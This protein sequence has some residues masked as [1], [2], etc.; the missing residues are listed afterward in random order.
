MYKKNLERWLLN[1]F[2]V[3]PLFFS[4]L[5]ASKFQIRK[6]EGE[7]KISAYLWGYLWWDHSLFTKWR[8]HN[9]IIYTLFKEPLPPPL[10]QEVI[11]HVRRKIIPEIMCWIN[12]IECCKILT[13]RHSAGSRMTIK[14]AKL[15]SVS[16]KCFYCQ[17][18]TLLSVTISTALFIHSKWKTSATALSFLNRR[19]IPHMHASFY[20]LT[21]QDCRKP[22]FN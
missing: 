8:V 14:Q 6:E 2:T 22:C 17:L 5:D 12:T 16:I 7:R 9:P 19:I 21:K 1:V 20:A 11:F 10:L 13:T 15:L 18:R 4:P 3:T